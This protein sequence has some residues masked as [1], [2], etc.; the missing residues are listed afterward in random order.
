MVI[1]IIYRLCKTANLLMIGYGLIVG[2]VSPAL[3]ILASENT[4]L[5]SGKLT[6][7]EISYIGSVNCLG[8]LFGCISF[9]FFISVFGC[10][11][12]LL[13]STFPCIAFWFLIYFGNHYYYILLARFGGGFVGGGLQTII[14]L[15]IA[16]IAN[17][18]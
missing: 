2:W 4:P 3:P 7:E 14:L 1:K 17:D 15:F 16:E 8:A 11:K 12:L 5:V 9:G 13:F 18:K 6:N 10:K